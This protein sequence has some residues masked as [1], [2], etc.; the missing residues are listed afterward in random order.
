MRTVTPR[1]TESPP[2]ENS[3]GDTPG[4][5]GTGGTPAPPHDLDAPRRT[6][7][8]LAR[9]LAVPLLAYGAS[10]LITTAAVALAALAGRHSLHYVFT[11]WDGRWYERIALSGYPTSVPQGDF[12]AGT[13]RQ[14][15]S[16]VAFFP[17]YPVLVRALDYVLPGGADV[18]GVVLSFLVGALATVVV[19]LVAD[20]VAGRPVADRAA[21]LFAFSPG[22]FVLSLVYAEGLLILLSAG[23]LLALLERRWVMAGLLAAL[24]TATRPNGTAVVMACAWAAAVAIWKRRE[25]RALAAPLLA[26]VGMVLF[27][28]FLWWHTGESLI[29][30]RVQYQGW[31]ERI[32]FGLANAKL[33]ADFAT[34]PFH[35]PNKAVLIGSM[36]FAVVLMV[37]LVRAK[38]PGVLN[39]YALGGLGVVL[40]SHINARPRFIF[41]A[42][43]LVI[44]L[45]K[46]VRRP[47]AFMVLAGTFAA[48]T[49]M[50][51]V[52][53]GLHRANYYP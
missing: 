4:P 19:W 17:L 40:A 35:N 33:I 28:V 27:F 49:V 25:W 23:C 26:P 13:G 20:K 42:F 53:Y 31:G 10:R 18:A 11:V 32:D 39:V 22:A 21:V 36:V 29:W 52:F 48:S 8:S 15:Q 1:S 34:H 9:P 46:T 12:Y 7:S 44:A 6:L 5:P 50:L 43:P 30:F 51:T 24:A 45:A 38:L 2:P 3:P 47:P 37:V 16:S 14:V 41:V